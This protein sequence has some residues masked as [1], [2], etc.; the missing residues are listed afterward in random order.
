MKRCNRKYY[1]RKIRVITLIISVLYICGG[2]VPTVAHAFLHQHEMPESSCKCDKNIP[3]HF[4]K[5]IYDLNFHAK[6]PVCQQGNVFALIVCNSGYYQFAFGKKKQ[7]QIEFSKK[8]SAEFSTS[9]P[10]APPII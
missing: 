6:C 2:I 8:Y 3:A 9:A 4:H 1:Q 5:V 7:K 10:R